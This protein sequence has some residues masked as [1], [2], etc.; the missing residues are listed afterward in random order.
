MPRVEMEASYRLH[1]S[2]VSLAE[3]SLHGN[4]TMFS[5]IFNTEVKADD[6]GI[7]VLIW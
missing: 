1:V 5:Y 3:T 4:T 7:N 2:Y 6:S